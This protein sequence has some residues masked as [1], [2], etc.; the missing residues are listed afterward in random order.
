MRGGLW[1]SGV[2]APGPELWPKRLGPTSGLFENPNVPAGE[3]ALNASGR[4]FKEA[5]LF[6]VRTCI[7]LNHVLR[8]EG[9]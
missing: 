3:T 5:P 9:D 8:T 1:L 6:S 7:S 4:S 2:L